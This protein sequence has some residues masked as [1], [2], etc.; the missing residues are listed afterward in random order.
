M[1]SNEKHFYIIEFKSEEFESQHG[2]YADLS[3]INS[4]HGLYT[5]YIV[6]PLKEKSAYFNKHGKID[7]KYFEKKMIVK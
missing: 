6:Y 2:L 5:L 1:T 4:Y 7:A 3:L